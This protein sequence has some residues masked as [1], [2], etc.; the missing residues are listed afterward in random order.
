MPLRRGFI[1]VLLACATSI[2]SAEENPLW[3]AGFGFFALTSP[4]Y[5]GSDE[6][7]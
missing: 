5:R 6:S 1:A 3:E 4:D 7:R 2:S